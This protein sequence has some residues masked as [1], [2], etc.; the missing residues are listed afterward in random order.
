[1]ASGKDAARDV[2]DLEIRVPC[3]DDLIIKKAATGRPKDLEDLRVLTEIRRR[4]S[5]Q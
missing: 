2:A 1:M 5:K 4:R 3:L